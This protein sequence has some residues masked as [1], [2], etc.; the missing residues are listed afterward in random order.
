M[1]SN[2]G[3][4]MVEP[5]G[6][7]AIG[8]VIVVLKFA[9]LVPAAKSH[10]L[11]TIV[12]PRGIRDEFARPGES[13]A[14]IWILVM[15]ACAGA[16]GMKQIA[17][18]SIAPQPKIGPVRVMSSLPRCPGSRDRYARARRA[19]KWPRVRRETKRDGRSGVR[20]T[21]NFTSAQRM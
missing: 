7:F 12:Y 17:N 18:A 3:P 14:V 19:V 16:A 11:Q 8:S 6:Y 10:P 2:A 21:C 15:R 9:V 13:T 5:S 4:A 20:R 1:Y